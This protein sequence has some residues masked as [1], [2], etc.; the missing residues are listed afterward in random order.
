MGEWSFQTVV[1]TKNILNSCEERDYKMCVI[2]MAN[3][4]RPTEEMLR[5]AWAA[6]SHGG[7]IAWQQ[8]GDT[9]WHKGI[10]DEDNFVKLCLEAPLPY[11]AHFRVAS[12]GGV[13]KELTHP[14]IISKEAPLQL[15]GKGKVAV[16]FH[17]GHWSDWDDKALDAAINA[18]VPVPDGPW[19]DTRAIAW[20]CSIYGFGFMELL[21]KQR[22]AIVTPKRMHLFTGPGWEKINDVWCSNDIFW[23]RGIVHY[24]SSTRIC[25]R[26]KCTN[27]AMAGKDVCY[28]CN[29]AADHSK[30]SSSGG[31]STASPFVGPKRETPQVV[32]PLTSSEA[33]MLQKKGEISRN[34][35]KKIRN[36]H[37]KLAAGPTENKKIRYERELME[38]TQVAMARLCSQ[39]TS[40]HVH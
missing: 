5:K 31:S 40:G 22:G 16:L 30:K 32:R 37:S 9:V 6:N 17:N 2:M 28:T 34:L 14:F 24:S 10:M 13:C 29:S 18:N 23:K 3:K 39:N 15:S 26:G 20:L 25:S 1:V 38:Y 21:T 19:S 35:Y 11:V 7:G 8:G 4:T 12:I 36:L 27:N 33:E